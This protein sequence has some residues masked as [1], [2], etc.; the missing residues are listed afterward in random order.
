[1]K[2]PSRLLVYIAL[3]AII[4]Y[5]FSSCRQPTDPKISVTG[6]SLNKSTL[7]MVIGSTA[8]LIPTIQP[9]NATYKYVNWTSSNKAV[10]TVN[11]AGKVTAITAGTTIITVIT[12]DGDKSASCTVTV[13][14]QTQNPRASDFIISNLTQT[15]GN[16]VAVTI[17]PKEGKSS[18]AI[19]IY[20]EGM[21]STNYPK[22]RTMPSVVGIYNVTFDVA[23]ASG[24]YAI[25]DLPGGTLTINV[26]N[27]S[28]VANDFQISNLTQAYG[29][30][31][32]VTITPNVGKSSGIVTIY[33][34]GSGGT[35]YAKSNTL[36][37][38]VGTYTITFNVAAAT[39]FNAVTGLAGGTL[40]INEQ[41]DAQTPNII[42][43]PE[44]ITVTVD[45]LFSLS[46]TASSLDGGEISYSW[47]SNTD[48]S[49]IGGTV[50]TEATS[51]SYTLPTSTAGTYYYF[52]E[53]T[54][55][56]PDNNDGGIKI[57]C[58]RSNAV[59]ICVQ[60]LSVFEI[61]LSIMDEWELTEQAVQVGAYF[62]K[63][64]TVKG[65]YVTYQ[66]LLDGTLVETSPNYVFNKPANVYQLA[67]I[68]T[69]NNGESRS[70]R[71]R[72][73][74]GT[75]DFEGTTHSF[76]IVNGSQTNQWRV[77]TAVAAS[78]T[79][80]AYISNNNGVSNS[81]TI[82][83]SSIVHMYCDIILP[84]STK[85]YTLSF[86]WRGMGESGYDDLTVRL[87]DISN[88]PSANNIPTGTSLGTFTGSSLWNKATIIIPISNNGTSK[89]L[90][91]TWRNNNYGGTQPP[92][93][94]DNI[95]INQ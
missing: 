11:T 37:L 70:G 3:I 88:T 79:K 42:T 47:Y 2:I 90:V 82:T 1:M 77:G 57:A 72:I 63:V 49:N 65:T 55:T 45:S 91:F 6:V 16:I 5:S 81:Y 25:T 7:S 36:P 27:Q 87:I 86:D 44:S 13:A 35:I 53:I 94:I 8:D 17:T 58:L 38:A 71:C 40:T 46:V 15:V 95:S 51:A 76:T 59:E 54:N 14:S 41:V 28:P 67:V 84:I 92:A 78:G 19:T 60:S 30:V 12:E 4:G 20:Y 24:F 48:M 43:H 89:R 29:N 33:Y 32:A 80:S 31:T 18:G 74:V 73:S 69:N 93:A 10:A 9:E 39:G 22:V 26:T 68:V 50:I 61:N 85:A 56:I 64:F 34:E 83:S 52:V 23:A 21:G 66:W 62:N 75:E